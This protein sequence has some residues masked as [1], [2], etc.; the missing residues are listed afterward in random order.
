MLKWL[1]LPGVAARKSVLPRGAA[2]TQ[3]GVRGA[4]PAPSPP[5]GCGAGTFPPPVERRVGKTPPLSHRGAGKGCVGL[6]RAGFCK[7]RIDISPFPHLSLAGNKTKRSPQR[8]KKRK[9]EI[10]PQRGARVRRPLGF[11]SR[12]GHSPGW[13]REQGVSRGRAG[14]APPRCCQGE[15]TQHETSSPCKGSRPPPPLLK[16]EPGPPKSRIREQ[17]RRGRGKPRQARSQRGVFK[18]SQDWNLAET[19]RSRRQSLSSLFPRPV[20]SGPQP[21][22][23]PRRL[24]STR[25]CGRG[26]PRCGTPARWEPSAAAL[27]ARGARAR[28][29]PAAQLRALGRAPPPPPP[30][31]PCSLARRL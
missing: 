15:E 20:R 8:K 18:N 5:A 21:R 22:N 25:G 6:E 24:C 17:R 23:C 1:P 30:R 26:E 19:R 4:L 11:V 27:R 10:K 13:G 31:A 12:Q 14:R 2:F 9:K 3:P 7:P 28:P 16:P 29:P